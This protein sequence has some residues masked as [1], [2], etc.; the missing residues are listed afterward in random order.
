MCV[1]R[2]LQYKL[3]YISRVF[4]GLP[5]IP[6]PRDG[7]EEW[8]Y[9]IS[10]ERD[11]TTG[12]PVDI[13]TKR[14]KTCLK[15]NAWRKSKLAVISM[16]PLFHT[17]KKKQSPHQANKFQRD[18]PKMASFQRGL[19]K[20]QGKSILTYK[21]SLWRSK[22]AAKAVW[23]SNLNREDTEENSFAKVAHIWK[24][25]NSEI[26][27]PRALTLNAKRT[28]KMSASTGQASDQPLSL[29]CMRIFQSGFC[30]SGNEWMAWLPEDW[31]RY[32]ITHRL[33]R[34]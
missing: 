20:G 15:I 29:F 25:N 2:N 24:P 3:S 23:R 34:E 7:G 8:L 16:Q 6:L 11:C 33:G 32:L 22:S 13:R 4:K 21:L 19:E 10:G 14:L 26:W 18:L 27:A 5:A 17:S 31:K 28:L 9:V 1:P 30:V 12:W